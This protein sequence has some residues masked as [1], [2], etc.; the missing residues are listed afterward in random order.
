[1]LPDLQHSWTSWRE[2]PLVLPLGMHHPLHPHHD[3]QRKGQGEVWHRRRYYKWCF[4]GLLLWMLLPDPNSQWSER[5]WSLK[6][7]IEL[8]CHKFELLQ[9][10]T[11]S[12]SI[13]KLI[14]LLLDIKSNKWRF[15]WTLSYLQCFEKE[16]RYLH[17]FVKWYQ[18]NMHTLIIWS[19]QHLYLNNIF[20][21]Y[22]FIWIHPFV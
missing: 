17:G 15:L 11:I 18:E 21:G 10:N 13:F 5:T 12:I 9:Y 4:D 8:N 6:I 16:Y 1:M 19:K 14:L 2:W 20:S 7:Q 22:Q 3:A